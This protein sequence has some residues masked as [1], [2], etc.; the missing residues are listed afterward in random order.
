MNKF[1]IFIFWLLATSGILAQNDT[2]DVEYTLEQV[3]L[4]ANRDVQNLRNVSQSVH[5]IGARQ[6]NL[7]QPQNMADLLI[8]SGAAFVQKS[9]QGGG[10]P[11]LRG[12]E[13]NKILLVIDGVRMNNAIY[14]GGHLQNILSLD[15]LSLD[16]VEVL[17]GPSSSVYGSDAL[18]G[19]I[20]LYTRKPIFALEGEKSNFGLRGMVRYGSANQENTAHLDF[21]V[22]S[23]KLASWTSVTASRFGDLTMGKVINAALGSSFGER[24]YYVSRINNIDSV[25]TNRDKYV[26]VGSG[27]SQIDIIQ[28]LSHRLTDQISHGVNLQLSTTTDVPRY[29]RLTDL[30]NSTD[31]KSLRQSEWY[32]GPQKRLMAAYDIQSSQGNDTKWHLGIAYQNIEE[33]R[34]TRGFRSS[35]L[36]SRVEKLDIIS[37]TADKYF[38]AGNHKLRYG[39]DG[40]HNILSSTATATMIKDQTVRPAST[41]YPDGNNRMTNMGA[42]VSHTWNPSINWTFNHGAR[43]GYTSLVS[44]FVSKTF[45]PFPFDKAEQNHLVYSGSIGAVYHPWKNGK[46]GY[47]LSSGF[48]VP[49][50]DDLSKVFETTST[51]LIVPNPGLKPEKTLNAEINGIIN[52]G[53]KISLEGAL[54]H[55]WLTDAIVVDRYSFEGSDS[56]VYNGIKAGVLASQNR[57]QA[58]IYGCSFQAK[59]KISS[60]ISLQGSLQYTVGNV[61]INQVNSPLDHIPPAIGRLAIQFQKDRLNA[62]IFS[63]INGWKRLKD[64]STSG[65][66]NLQYATPEG[67]PSWYTLNARVSYM[68]TNRISINLGIENILDLQYR[69]FASGINAAGRNLS[70]ML[71]YEM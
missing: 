6:I 61:N 32:Y 5:V 64:Y 26:Q 42:Y 25:V 35:S 1:K 37:F 62:T 58:R 15:A 39:L 30:S 66:D 51:T 33:S 65:E 16:K 27:Y 4:S 63:I 31:P 38:K 71:K 18:G 23:N 49:N 59:A 45:F 3:V 12:F 48:R 14:R 21:N 19:V 44:T 56:I 10:S 55:T 43:V 50:I 54:Y 2:I 13:A 68:A 34:H 29:D 57:D 28:K 67:M 70:I 46:I 41:R 69:Y 22:G 52:I 11:V 40:Q 17:S 9:Q 47:N 36:I 20:H 24:P 7:L 60:H 8:N 53:S